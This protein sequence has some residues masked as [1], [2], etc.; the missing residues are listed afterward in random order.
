MR[1]HTQMALRNCNYL[2]KILLLKIK[3][4]IVDNNSLNLKF[5]LKEI[6][7][8]LK[9]NNGHGKL[10]LL[11]KINADIMRLIQLISLK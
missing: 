1:G 4:S 11:L 7:L 2:I 3:T 9:Q 5:K 8:L 10:F 6:F